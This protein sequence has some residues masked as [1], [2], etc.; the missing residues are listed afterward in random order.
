[1]SVAGLSFREKYADAQASRR[2]LP[3]ARE[4]L[5]RN[6]QAKTGTGHA[7]AAGSPEYIVS[8]WAHRAKRT[9]TRAAECRRSIW[10]D[11]DGHIGNPAAARPLTLRSRSSR[12]ESSAGRQQ[13]GP[14]GAAI[15]RASMIGPVVDQLLGWLETAVPVAVQPQA[16][17]IVRLRIERRRR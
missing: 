12:P 9:L 11:T 17:T 14:P 1:M 5:E 16:D 3:A 10:P 4:R 13:S 8:R 6:R 7:D 2:S 15:L